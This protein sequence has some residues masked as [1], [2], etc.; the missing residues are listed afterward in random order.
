MSQQKKKY[1]APK[2]RPEATLT[3]LTQLVQVSTGAG[4]GGATVDDDADL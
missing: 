2:L 1:Q 3:T 4:D